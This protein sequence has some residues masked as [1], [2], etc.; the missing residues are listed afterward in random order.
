MKRKVAAN[1]KNA[2]KTALKLGAF[3]GWW[4][5]VFFVLKLLGRNIKRINIK[6]RTKGNKDKLKNKV[7]KQKNKMS[8]TALKMKDLK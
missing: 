1:P 7:A 5:C 8:C 4:W 2:S 3:L 6:G